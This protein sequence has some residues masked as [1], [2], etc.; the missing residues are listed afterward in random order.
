MS[1]GEVQ[2]AP[3]TITFSNIAVANVNQTTVDVSWDVAPNAQGEVRYGLADGGPYP[4]VHTR[5]TDFLPSHVQRIIGLEETTTY[6]FVVWGRDALGNEDI[7]DQET[8]TTEGTAPS[9]YPDLIPLA[10]LAKPTFTV[11]AQLEVKTDPQYDCEV[12]QVASLAGVRYASK[13]VLNADQ[14]MGVLDKPVVGGARIL[15]D[16][17]T[18]QTLKTNLTTYG[19]FTWDPSTPT[20]AFAYSNP[21]IVRVLSVSPTT[22]TSIVSSTTLTGW[23]QIGLGGNQGSCS[24]DGRYLAIQGQKTNGSLWYAVFDTTT[25]SISAEVQVA[26]SGTLSIFDA[27]G[28]SQSGTY[29]IGCFAG[30]GTGQTQGIKAYVRSTMSLA[31]SRHLTTGGDH[32]DAGLLEDGTTDVI[33]ACNQ[34]VSGGTEAFGASAHVGMYQLSNGAYTPLVAN[35]P[36]GHVSCRNTQRPGYCYPSTYSDIDTNPTHPGYGTV[37]AV[38]FS[39]PPFTG[40]DVEVFMNIHGPSSTAYNDQPNTCPSPDGT[41]AFANSTW[42][43]APVVA[44]AAGKDVVRI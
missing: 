5:E 34:S 35:W 10:Y 15:F 40:G 38:R 12:T 21:N 25:L 36:N 9:D 4:F 6:Y 19:A 7:S 37:F 2:E 32:W 11:P 28:I 41:R 33:V 18:L 42:D 17:Q 43:G 39:D 8:F 27:C 13:S 16:G 30:N 44:L 14:S 31:T 26:A 24:N 29:F 20:R 1:W 22:G 3:A 23:T